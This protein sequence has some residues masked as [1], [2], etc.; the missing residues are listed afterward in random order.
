MAGSLMR[1]GVAVGAGVLVAG[2]LMAVG[3]PALAAV[4]GPQVF[5]ADG[6]WVVPAGVG[7]VSIG[8]DGA[9]GG[10]GGS[11]FDDGLLA[12]G[13]G[14]STA[15]TVVVAPGDTLRV[16]IGG[17]G[18][19]G[20]FLMAPIPGGA[21]GGGNAGDLDGVGNSGG[22]GGGASDVRLNG[23]AL[24]DR[25]VV[26]GGGGGGGGWFGGG[27]GGAGPFGGG[28]GGGSG[29]AAPDATNVTQTSGVRSGDGHVTI[30]PFAAPP[31]TTPPT[32]SPAVT[33]DGNGD[34]SGADDGAGEGTGDP[35]VPTA[36]P[37]GEGTAPG[38]NMPAALFAVLVA[39]G[40]AVLFPVYRSGKRSH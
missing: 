27:G 35:A 5:T 2:G 11:P 40:A 37:A 38:P 19:N 20:N 32:S 16:F 9:Q 25:I 7:S 24:A 29:Y 18:Q 14:G 6:S 15:A 4:P 8:A 23:T 28:G 30:T 33:D 12:G 10:D 3:S 1:A 21:N 17:A 26:A 22:S 39:L 13:L 31:A 34:G 36:V